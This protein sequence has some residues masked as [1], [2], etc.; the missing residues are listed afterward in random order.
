MGLRCKGTLVFFPGSLTLPCLVSYKQYNIPNPAVE[1]WADSSEK[2]P[3][4]MR[5]MRR[6]RSS[7]ACAKYHPGLFYPFIQSGVSNGHVSGQ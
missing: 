2:V 5:K 7:C 1:I 4:N 3:S 6:F